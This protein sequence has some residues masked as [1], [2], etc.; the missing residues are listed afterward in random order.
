MLSIKISKSNTRPEI[1]QQYLAVEIIDWPEDVV[2]E[3]A[4]G[5]WHLSARALQERYCMVHTTAKGKNQ[6]LAVIEIDPN[7]WETRPEDGDR[8][9]SGRVLPADHPLV[10]NWIG[11]ESPIGAKSQTSFG[12]F[13]DTDLGANQFA[14]LGKASEAPS[15]RATECSRGCSP[16]LKQ[17]IGSLCLGCE[18]QI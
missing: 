12:Y 11:R 15:S 4:R 7:G 8:R 9:F 5:W 18:E 2:Y 13:V 6:I 10:Q 17:P 14:R 3:A 16:G 1:P